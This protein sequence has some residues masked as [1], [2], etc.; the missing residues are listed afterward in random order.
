MYESLSHWELAFGKGQFDPDFFIAFLA[1]NF[2]DIDFQISPF[3]PY[4]NHFKRSL[5]SLFDPYF[6]RLK[7]WASLHA[8]L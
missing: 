6:S 5:F 1:P 4:I 2:L 3:L 7:A 8:F